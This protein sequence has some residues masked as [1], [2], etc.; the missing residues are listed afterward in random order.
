M[1]L[2]ICTDLD[3][4][5]LDAETY[6]WRAAQPALQLLKFYECPIILV[7]S[8]T[9]AEMVPIQRDLGIVDPF[10]VENGGG[11]VFR[12]GTPVAAVLASQGRSSDVVGNGDL[13]MLPMGKKYQ[14]LLVTLEEISSEVG[15]P[16]PGFGSMSDTEVSALT[17]LPLEEAARARVRHFDEPFIALREAPGLDDHIEQAAVRRGM[18]A[19][20]GGRFWHLMGHGGKGEATSMLIECYRYLYGQIVVVGL[21][22]SPNDFPFLEIV[23]IPVL[24]G[25]ASGPASLPLTLPRRCRLGKPGPQGWSD[26]VLDI[27][28][29]MKMFRAESHQKSAESFRSGDGWSVALRELESP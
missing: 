24:L 26:A 22:D 15:S 23:D 10:I 18:M 14:D 29:E 11:I 19:V 25:M 4:T 27:L 9:L 16:L 28:S 20:K 5:L 21:G 12:P 6:S 3:G 2:L 8:K 13:M 7:S 1:K 17:G